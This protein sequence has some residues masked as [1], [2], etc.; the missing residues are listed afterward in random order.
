MPCARDTRYSLTIVAGTLTAKHTR[1]LI[2]INWLAKWNRLMEV[3]LEAILMNDVGTTFIILPFVWVIV[4][5]KVCRKQYPK[6]VGSS[7][8]YKAEFLDLFFDLDFS[9]TSVYFSY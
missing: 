3:V 1:N 6:S 8:Y 2:K 9:A 5:A 4:L 7:S